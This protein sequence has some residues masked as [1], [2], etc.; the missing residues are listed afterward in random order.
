MRNEGL[1][2]WPAR[3]ARRSPDRVALIYQG[4]TVTYRRLHLRVLRLAHNL[5]ELGVRR[6]DRVAYLG[7]N[8]PSFLEA[9]FATGL[10]GGVFV[11]LNTRLTAAEIDYQVAD[12]AASALLHTPS[13]DALVRSLTAGPRV[14]LSVVEPPE[15]P[16]P[17]YE[18][19]DE[20]VAL[21]D[22]CMIM[23]TSGTTGRPKGAMLTHGGVTWNSVD[24]MIDQDLTA[25]DVALAAAPLFHTAGLNMVALPML[26]KGGT[27]VVVPA[28]DPEE[29]LDL[30]ERHQITTMFGVPTMFEQVAR[31]R[32]WADADLSSLRLLTCGG[33]PVPPSLIAAYA[34]RGLALVQG[35]GLTEAGPAASFLD[36]GSAAA[37]AGSAG[38][39]HFFTDVRVAGPDHAETPPG[40][41][42]EILV[43]GPHV[44]SGYWGLPAETARAFADGWLRTGDAAR[45]DEDGHVY[46]VDRVKDMII[47]GGENIY[48]AEVEQ[49][50]MAEPDV[51]DCAVIGVPDDTWGEVG[52]A[53]VVPRPGS[54]LTEAGLLAALDG[55]LARYK[56]PKSVVL[57]DVIPR[58]PTGKSRKDRL[59]EAYGGV[60][61]G[62]RA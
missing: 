32:R 6:G 30:I 21:D 15:P 8:H 23:Y 13:H 33:A 1:G 61:P 20:P 57:A 28:F 56:I 37:K 22:T 31:S 40:E 38:T 50:I 60:T 35:Y 55:R 49:V 4:R 45:R 44:M 29:T 59:R 26:L 10:L 14:L 27:C 34:D 11:P 2:S 17:S 18:P 12:S 36:P 39:P 46:V 7:P 3:R 25:A 5:R 9:F 53:I 47:S 19:I 43:K 62:R 52:R 58:N 24:V 42:G 51:V 48:P 41:I 54:E 16:E